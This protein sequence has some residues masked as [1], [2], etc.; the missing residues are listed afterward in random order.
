MK[1][2]SKGLLMAFLMA[3]SGLSAANYTNEVLAI[4]VGARP[5]G[6][7]GAFVGMADD[8]S[9]V[10]WNPAGLPAINHI[11]VAAIQQGRQ[12]GDMIN[13]VGSRYTFISGGMSMPNLG[14]FGVGFLRF[15]V[16]DIPYVDPNNPTNA[17]IINGT[18]SNAEPVV[19]GTFKQQDLAL[20]GA[21]GKSVLPMLKVGVALKMVTGGTDG[22]P[23]NASYNYLGA[24][25]AALLEFGPVVEALGGLSLGVNLQDLVNSGVAWSGTATNPVDKVDANPKIGLAY[26]PALS[27]LKSSQSKFSLLADVDPKYSP[28]SLWHFGAELWYKDT[29]ALRAGMRMFEEGMQENEISGGASVRFFLIQIDYAY[30]AYELTPIHYLSLSAKF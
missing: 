4:G 3:G 20:F 8:S 5:L 12:V 14:T 22:L 30:I 24:D 21:W 17:G 25:L 15:A 27:F 28:N 18:Q 19:G 2:F 13:E 6:M 29:I 1:R 10:Y 26:T 11:E 7:G 9:A 23:Q 16:D